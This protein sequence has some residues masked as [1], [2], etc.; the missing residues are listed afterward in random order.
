MS[1]LLIPIAFPDYKIAA[2]RTTWGHLGHAGILIVLSTT[3]LTKYYEY[4]RYETKN[5]GPPG[6]VKTRDVSSVNTKDG[7]VD[8][9]SLS[10]PLSE[11]SSQAGHGTRIEAA[12]IEQDHGFSKALGY[13]D[14]RLKQND[15]PNRDG[16]DLFSNNCGTFMQSV[17][18]AAGVDTPWMVD[19]RPNSY[20]DELRIDFPRLDFNTSDNKVV[21]TAA[22][23]GVLGTLKDAAVWLGTNV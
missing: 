6:I 22:D 23:R 16:Y 13:M 14:A 11:I 20:I 12:L 2:F 19:P 7:K 3:G 9:E 17:L 4:G 15:D 5:P 10:K 18:D 8:I 21:V 1:D